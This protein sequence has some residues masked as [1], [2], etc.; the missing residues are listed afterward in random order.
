MAVKVTIKTSDGK[1]YTN[2]ADVHIPRNEKTAMFYQLVDQYVP[3]K[4]KS[5]DK[6]A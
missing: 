2:P 4:E 5:G 3:K 6:T 1:V